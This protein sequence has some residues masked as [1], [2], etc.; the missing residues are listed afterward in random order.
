MRF[1]SRSANYRVVVRPDDDY[2]FYEEVKGNMMPKRVKRPALT[3]SFKHGIVPPDEAYAAM[4]HW[5]GTPSTRTDPERYDGSGNAVPDIFGAVPYQRP[6]TLRNS[7]NR[8]VA[9][10]AASRPDFNFS[11]FDTTWI[12]DPDDRQIAEDGLL[13]SSDYGNWFIKVE[14]EPIPAPWPN[15]DKVRRRG[16]KTIPDIILERVREDGYDVGHVI[17]YETSKLN[18]EEVLARLNEYAAE[19]QEKAALDEAME[20]EVA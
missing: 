13:S 10:T 14:K 8:I 17:A 15:Y 11:L 5:N 7:E 9:V 20:V 1:V 6:I 12:E 16:N 18:R 2:E 3:C 19:L 4:L